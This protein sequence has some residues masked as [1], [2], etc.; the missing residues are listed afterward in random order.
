MCVRVTTEQCFQHIVLIVAPQL[1][2]VQVF[3]IQGFAG[4]LRL[5][6]NVNCLAPTANP[7]IIFE[8]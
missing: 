1:E 7:A 8:L 2:D 5:S 4:K 6:S 3:T